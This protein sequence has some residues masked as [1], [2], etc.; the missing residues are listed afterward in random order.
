MLRRELSRRYPNIM[1][2]EEGRPEGRLQ[3][4]N[5]QAPTRRGSRQE[6]DEKKMEV[7]EEGRIRLY[8]EFE[9]L[10]D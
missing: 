9:S 3:P 8:D 1:A 4:G 10:D 5:G 2:L 6:A 7:E